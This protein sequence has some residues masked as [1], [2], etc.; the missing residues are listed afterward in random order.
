M[1]IWKEKAHTQDVKKEDVSDVQRKA[2]KTKEIICLI[3]TGTW[4][5][6]KPVSFDN[7]EGNTT[8]IFFFISKK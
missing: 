8:F 5:I 1:D 7:F 4:M 2:L 6:L 3:Y